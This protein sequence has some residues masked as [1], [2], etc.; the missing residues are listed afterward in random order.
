MFGADLIRRFIG[1]LRNILE[2]IVGKG[3]QR[4]S[5]L[6]ALTEPEKHQVLVEWNK[7]KREYPKYKCI[8]QLFEEQVKRT[9]EAVA[10]AFEDQQVTY[11]ELNN[12]VNHLAHYLH[13]QGVGPD[14]LVGICVNVP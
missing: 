11:R 4:I 1:H 14:V 8:H 12:R 3:D 9:P 6:S 7:T 5:E 13:K 10:V 2:G